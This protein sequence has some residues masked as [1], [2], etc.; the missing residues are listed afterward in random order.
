MTCRYRPKST[1]H[2]VNKNEPNGSETT[3]TKGIHALSD[4][5]KRPKN[6]RVLENECA[7]YDA[8]DPDESAFVRQAESHGGI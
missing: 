3:V 5:E 7:D 8:D 4:M 2:I 6:P 1:D